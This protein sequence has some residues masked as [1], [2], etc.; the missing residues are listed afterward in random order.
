M[1]TLTRDTTLAAANG[2]QVAALT[3]LS[4]SLA[5]LR[6]RAL[7]ELAAADQGDSELGFLGD[8]DSVRWVL[9]VP[10]L[11]GPSATQLLREAAH[12][13][14]KTI[15]IPRWRQGPAEVAVGPP[16]LGEGTNLNLVLSFSRP[17]SPA[18]TDRRPC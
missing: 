1:Q 5:H 7:A 18:R 8:D 13:V 4:M 9:T 14:R 12:M 10:A 17:D 3:V 2:R 15:G 16:T 6:D 11:W